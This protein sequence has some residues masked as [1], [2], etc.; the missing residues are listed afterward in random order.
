MMK[1]RLVRL[2]YRFAGDGLRVNFMPRGEDLDA[3]RAYAAQAA[4]N[5]K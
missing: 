1:D 3:M 5:V 4:E 2:G